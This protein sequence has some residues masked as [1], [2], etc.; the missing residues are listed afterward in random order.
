MLTSQFDAQ[1]GMAAYAA[2]KGALV[3]ITLPLARDL[4]RNGIRVNTLAPGVF[5]SPLTDRFSARTTA[6]VKQVLTF[7][8]RFGK[9]HEFAQAVRFILETGYVNGDVLK[10]SAATRMSPHL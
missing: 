10:L 2:A 3:S 5:T 1:A 8:A 6:G 4:A 7:P 9:A